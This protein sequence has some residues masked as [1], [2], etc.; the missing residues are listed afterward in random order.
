MEGSRQPHLCLMGSKKSA[1]A[2]DLD[3]FLLEMQ[4]R[5]VT[6]PSPEVGGAGAH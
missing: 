6:S 2:A 4:E 3:G 5:S 1:M